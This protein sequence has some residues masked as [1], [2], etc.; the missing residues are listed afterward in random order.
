MNHFLFENNFNEKLL[1][2]MFLFKIKIRNAN[3]KN[4][5][6]INNNFNSI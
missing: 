3:N 6:F 1:P 5:V 2:N 4:I